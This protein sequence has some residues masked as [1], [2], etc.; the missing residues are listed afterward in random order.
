MV[1]GRMAL[2]VTIFL[3]LVN[4]SNAASVINPKSEGLTAMDL[5]L[6][7][8][9]VFVAFA[10]FEYAILLKIRFKK[11]E[12]SKQ[13]GMLKCQCQN[14]DSKASVLFPIAFALFNLAYWLRI[15][16]GA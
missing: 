11:A 12:M 1:P 5:W 15:A 13:E 14:V 7:I 9:M 3:M 6:L 10:L 4:V 16:M 2:L 8:C